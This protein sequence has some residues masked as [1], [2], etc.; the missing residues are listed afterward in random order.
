MYWSLSASLTCRCMCRWRMSREIWNLPAMASRDA[1][2][3]R[4]ASM[5]ALSG[6]MQMLQEGPFLLL[7]LD[8]AVTVSGSV[9]AKCRYDAPGGRQD[10]FEWWW[11]ALVA[12]RTP[13]KR[14]IRA[15]NDGAAKQID[16]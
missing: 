10:P 13:S 6:C 14:L 2:A 4:V 11:N 12:V 9:S 16:A 3:T 5:R 8:L 15:A 7:N 1:P